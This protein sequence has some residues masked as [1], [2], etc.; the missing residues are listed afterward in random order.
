MEMSEA[1]KRALRLTS[2]WVLLFGTSAILTNCGK[3]STQTIG[4]PP[5]PPP[6]QVNNYVG[7]PANDSLDT[8]LW[9]VTLDHSKNVYSYGLSGSATPTTG[10]FSNLTGGFQVLLGPTGYQS[11]LALEVP[12][13]AIILRPGDTT[14]APIFA[15][16]QAF[17]FAIDGNVKFL[18]DLSPGSTQTNGQAFF[19]RVY[20]AT[21]AGGTSWQFNNLTQYQIPDGKDVPPDAIFPTYPGSYPGTCSASN[22]AAAVAAAPLENFNLTAGGSTYPVPTEYAISPAGF[23]FADQSYVNV[24]SGTGWTIPNIS[25]WGVSEPAA[26][27]AVGG[28]GTANYVGFLFE[29]GQGGGYR[30][31]LVGFGNAPV[32]GTTMTGGTFPSEDPTQLPTIN[33]SVTFGSQDP[34]NNGVYY[35]AKLTTPADG[36]LF[37]SSC[38]SYGVSQDGAQTCINNAVATVGQPNGR[39]AIVLSAIDTSGHQQMLVLFQQ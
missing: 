5:P 14:T 11:G 36:S 7:Q 34:L 12:G 39:Y 24:P 21:D 29:I 8:T 3:S 32:A 4:L 38:S 31:R 23:F 35:L 33:M 16:E 13:E 9:S 37:T 26:P 30:T 10:S 19:G 22:G 28:V 6:G 1:T 17:C 18:F 2:F 25:A 15:V 27:L 20:A